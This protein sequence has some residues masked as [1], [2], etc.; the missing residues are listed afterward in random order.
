MSN[1][2]GVA[3]KLFRLIVSLNHHH[4]NCVVAVTSSSLQVRT[5]R[6]RKE[7]CP[8]QCRRFRRWRRQGSI[9][10]NL[11]QELLNLDT[12]LHY[13]CSSPQGE[14]KSWGHLETIWGPF[15]YF[16]SQLPGTEIFCHYYVTIKSLF[17]HA[18]P[19]PSPTHTPTQPHPQP[20]T[21]THNAVS[22]RMS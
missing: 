11:G 4:Q 15:C 20:T 13:L 2:L 19:T 6:H 21:H 3:Y 17:D 16:P 9:P 12:R 18:V 14:V 5:Q 7:T 22:S 10:G 8:R 1:A